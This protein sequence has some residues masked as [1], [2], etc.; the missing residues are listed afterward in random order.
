MCNEFNNFLL[1]LVNKLDI[2]KGSLII[3]SCCK[4]KFT[5]SCSGKSIFIDAKTVEGI[6]C[7]KSLKNG[8]C[9]RIGNHSKY[10]YYKDSSPK[11]TVLFVVLNNMSIWEFHV[12]QHFKNSHP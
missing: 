7:V 4:N 5:S 11:N 12:A 2:Q 3:L 9:P 10:L 8:T 1:S 6:N